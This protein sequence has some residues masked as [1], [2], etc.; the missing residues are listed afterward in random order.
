MKNIFWITLCVILSIGCKEEI[1][2]RVQQAYTSGAKK[3]ESDFIEDGKNEIARRYYQENGQILMEGPMKTGKREGEWKFFDY[4][5][6]LKSIRN[7]SG[8][9]YN[10]SYEEFYKNGQVSLSGTYANGDR[11]G[12]WKKFNEKG[13]EEAVEETG[14]ITPLT[15]NLSNE[16]ITETYPDGKPKTK[17]IY[18]ETG[19]V[20]LQQRSYY[21]E[22][23]VMIEGIFK[24]GKRNGQWTSYYQNG[25]KQSVNYYLDDQTHGDYMLYH[26]NGIIK[27]E[28]EYNFGIQT[29][30]WKAYDEDGTLLTYNY[31][32]AE[33]NLMDKIK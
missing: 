12:D 29:G 15:P 19:T 32:D 22:G 4:D 26:E 7:Y 8:G 24:D 11:V 25:K 1:S 9:T 2:T 31:Y 28:G 27:I 6:D 17:L 20:L 33:G 5:G 14:I 16:K 21:P 10:G 13:E 18:D 30:G 23:Q 3:I